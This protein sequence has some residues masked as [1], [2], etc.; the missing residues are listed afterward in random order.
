M[1]GIRMNKFSFLRST[2]VRSPDIWEAPPTP[3]FNGPPQPEEPVCLVGDLHGCAGL[4]SRLLARRRQHFPEHRLIVL[5]DMIDRGEESARV[6][7]LLGEEAAAGAVCLRGNHEEM[8]LAFLDNPVQAGRRWLHHGGLSTLASF[9]WRGI[10][11]D[12]ASRVRARDVICEQMAPGTVDWLR[13]LP[14][15]WQSGDLVAVHAGLDP[16]LPVEEQKTSTLVWGHSAFE[17]QPRT[18]GLYVAYGHTVV[19]RPHLRDGKLAIDTGAYATG[20]LSYALIDPAAPDPERIVFGE[21]R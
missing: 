2:R 8:F 4:L 17:W 9:G 7:E 6:L 1:I 19:R 13:S 16:G 20:T 21:V 14:L 15:I 18:D 5:G 10:P 11:S 3:I 12:R